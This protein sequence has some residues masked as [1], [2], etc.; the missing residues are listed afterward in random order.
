VIFSNIKNF[1]ENKSNEKILPLWILLE[2]F[3]LPDRKEIEEKK[4]ALCERIFDPSTALVGYRSSKQHVLCTLHGVNTGLGHIRIGDV[5][6]VNYG[7]QYLP[8]SDC[9][10][11]GI[12]GNTLSDQG[13]RRPLIE[14]NSNSFTIKGCVR[15]VDQP[16]ALHKKF[17]GIWVD[18]AQDFKRPHFY[19]NATFLSLDGWDSVVFSFFIKARRC[20]VYSRPTPLLPRTLERYEGNIEPLIL[21]GEHEQLILRAVSQE[22][23]MQIIPLGGGDN[24]W[25]ADFIISYILVPEVSDYQWYIGP[26][27]S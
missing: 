8:L 24:F 20:C 26:Y 25:G 7:P 27:K 4:L 10:G 17:R 12:V 15:L 18:I 11:F 2:R 23:R 6:I 9:E 1:L 16:D 14:W 22:G 13:I 5:E 21:N 19:L 3:L